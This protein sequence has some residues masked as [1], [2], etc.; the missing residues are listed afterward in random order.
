MRLTANEVGVLK[1][2]RRFKSSRLRSTPTTLINTG[3]WVFIWHL[4]SSSKSRLVSATPSIGVLNRSSRIFSSR[5]NL[6]GKGGGLKKFVLA[7]ATVLFASG[8]ASTSANLAS[9]G[10]VQS[11]LE[12]SG[13]A[14]EEVSVREIS[15]NPQTILMVCS[16]GS[17]P[18]KTFSFLIWQSED[19][20]LESIS[21]TCQDPFT[22][23]VAKKPIAATGTLIAQTDSLLVD[24]RRISSAISGN[25]TTWID[26]CS[27]Q[28]FS[29]TIEDVQES[30][31]D[32]R[33]VVGLKFAE[34]ENLLE[35][36]GL[37]VLRVFEKSDQPEGVVVRMDP[38]EGTRVQK[39]TAITL[40]VS[41]GG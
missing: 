11:V 3:L 2:P 15:A 41:S 16:D 4:A 24:A 17:T 29:P 18:E 6:N 36:D 33:D 14:C 38:L 40:Y 19:Q 39:G 27:E 20:L 10:E 8:C 21:E 12:N 7:V 9:A 22:P 31:L 5:C 23:S 1:A 28:G 35:K 26:L 37:L 34:A 13:I 30:T 32:L 25:T